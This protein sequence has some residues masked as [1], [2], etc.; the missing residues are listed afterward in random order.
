MREEYTYFLVVI[1]LKLDLN[2]KQ[3]IP[4][5]NIIKY[6][7]LYNIYIDI[8]KVNK[9]VK[10]WLMLVLADFN[11]CFLIKDLKVINP[12]KISEFYLNQWVEKNEI[13]NK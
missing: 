3:I 1:I 8:I 10:W 6:I 2:K 11:R 9:P 4:Y 5:L 7:N 12:P 13:R